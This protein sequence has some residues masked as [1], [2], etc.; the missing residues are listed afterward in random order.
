MKRSKWVYEGQPIHCK[1]CGF[2]PTFSLNDKN[3]NY[4]PCCGA[5]MRGVSAAELKAKLIEYLNRQKINAMNRRA[6]YP[7]FMTEEKLRDEGRFDA[8]QDVLE[9]VERMEVDDES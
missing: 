8:Y 3:G 4:C 9:L 7:R 2:S 5:Y 1:A 6:Q